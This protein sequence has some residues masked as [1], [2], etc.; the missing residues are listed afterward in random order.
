MKTINEDIAKG[1]F[2]PVYLLYGEEPYLKNQYK[3]KLKNAILPDED[4][5]NFTRYEGKD[6]DVEQVISQAETMPFFAA[7]RLILIEESGFFKTASPRLAEYLPKMP[8]E[9]ILIFVE[10]EID[11]RGRLYKAVTACG[12]AAELKRPDERMLTNWVLGKIKKEGKQIRQDAFSLFREKTGN[13]MENI[14]QEL[15]KLLSYTMDREEITRKDVGTV[16]SGRTEDKVFDMVRAIAMREQKQALDLYYDLLALKK[17]PMQIL[18]LIA[19]QFNQMLEAADLSSQGYGSEKIASQMGLKS[20]YIVKR[21]LQQAAHFPEG[22]L[23]Q[24]VRDCVE[25]EEAVKTGKM[26]DQLAVEILIVKF[27]GTSS[28]QPSASL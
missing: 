22:Q 15:E 9:T 19:R 11:K 6:T 16:C 25:A 26:Q 12:H 20:S 3:N 14:E 4:L 23:M 1:Q 10:N 17:K 21:I 13:D 8:Q 7:H 2:R 24:A 28:A 18:S 27:S 5:M